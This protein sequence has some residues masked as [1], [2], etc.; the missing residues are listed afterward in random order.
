MH[1]QALAQMSLNLQGQW[2][3]QMMDPR[4][5]GPRAMEKPMQ[6]QAPARGRHFEQS[7]QSGV[8]QAQHPNMQRRGQFYM[9]GPQGLGKRLSVRNSSQ[10]LERSGIF[11]FQGPEKIGPMRRMKMERGGRSEN[12]K[13][14]RKKRKAGRG[15]KAD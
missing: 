10:S 3:A 5:P 15:S 2:N 7:R 14:G 6:E 4:G 12:A 1:P 8:L 9:G 11:F 13:G